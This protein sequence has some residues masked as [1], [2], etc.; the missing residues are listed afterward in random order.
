MILLRGFLFLVLLLL[1]DRL[2][3]VYFLR[4]IDLLGRQF[5]GNELSS[6]VRRVCCRH[7]QLFLSHA[8]AT[9][10]HT[11][12]IFLPHHHPDNTVGLD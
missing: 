5:L 9:S 8:W 12:S 10:P 7:F 3:G 2:L 1:E 11:S 6:S 4:F